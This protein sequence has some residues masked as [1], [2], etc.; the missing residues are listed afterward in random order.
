[1]RQ[2]WLAELPA[3]E[4]MTRVEFGRGF[5]AC[6]QITFEAFRAH[7]DELFRLAPVDHISFD[8][9]Q[10]EDAPA[11]ADSPHLARLTELSFVGRTDLRTQAEGITGSLA[12]DA[13]ATALATSPYLTR[14]T[15]LGFDRMGDAGLTAL[16][17]SPNIRRL[18]S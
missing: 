6:I 11:L 18:T 7:A 16:A 3:W 1:Y 4:G 10:E 8:N 13:V 9:F 5:I 12:S 15:G 17:G 14:L 2:S